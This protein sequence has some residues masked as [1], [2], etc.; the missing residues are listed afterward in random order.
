MARLG[1]TFGEADKDD[2]MIGPLCWKSTGRDI[3]VSDCLNFEDFSHYRNIVK[4]TVQ[5]F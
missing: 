5:G 1:R 4:R 2:R 3:A